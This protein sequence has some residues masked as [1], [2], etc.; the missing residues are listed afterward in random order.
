VSVARSESGLT[1]HVSRFTCFVR[2]GCGSFV[3]S[4]PGKVAGLHALSVQGCSGSVSSAAEPAAL[5]TRDT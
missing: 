5:Q 1:F 3:F 2:L 4:N